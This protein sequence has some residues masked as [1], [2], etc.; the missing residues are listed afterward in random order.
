MSRPIN[1]SLEHFLSVSGWVLLLA[2]LLTPST[3][4]ALVLGLLLAALVFTYLIETEGS[5]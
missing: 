5:S 3:R 2:M 1:P 4:V